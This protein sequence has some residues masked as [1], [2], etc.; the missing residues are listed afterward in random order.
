[1]PPF[2]L[3][4]TKKFQ[5]RIDNSRQW[6]PIGLGGVLRVTQALRQ[7]ERCRRVV[8]VFSI[9]PIVMWSANACSKYNCIRSG[10]LNS[11]SGVSFSNARSV[12]S[13]ASPINPEC[14]H[15]GAY[16]AEAF[17]EYMM[18]D[19]FCLS[20]NRGLAPPTSRISAR[21]S[22]YEKMHF[23]PSPGGNI[24]SQFAINRPTRNRRK[25][26]KSCKFRHSLLR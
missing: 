3:K 25:N 6:T 7:S 16:A 22:G 18:T 23:G 5:A 4:Q 9:E 17:L 1:M 12:R 10:A 21:E 14:C 13:R 20:L 26:D 15:T 11:K 24:R 19:I 2:A 8:L